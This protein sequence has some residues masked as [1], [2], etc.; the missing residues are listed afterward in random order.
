MKLAATSILFALLVLIPTVSAIGANYS[1]STTLAVQWLSKNQNSDGSWGDSD[2]LKFPCTEE[3]VLALMALNQHSSAYYWGTAWLE[4]HSAGNVDYATRR[5]LALAPHG[6]NVQADVTTIRSAQAIMQPPNDGWGLSQ[7]YQGSAMDSAFALMAFSQFKVLSSDAGVQAAISFLTSVRLTGGGWS[8]SQ[9]PSFDAPTT[10][11]VIEALTGY[12]SQTVN[13]LIA[14][15]ISSLSATVNSRSTTISQALAALAY[16]RADYPNDATALLNNLASTQ[17]Y[18]GSWSNGGSTSNELI[19]ATAIV[20]RSMATA[21]GSAASSNSKIVNI[22]DPHLRMAINKA[23]GRNSMDALTEGDMAELITL[24]AAG[25]GITDLTGLEWAVNLV[26]ADLSNNDITSTA[27]LANLNIASLNLSGNPCYTGSQGVASGQPATSGQWVQIGPEGGCILS[28]ATAP[29]ASGTVYAG[30]LNGGIY[31]SIDGCSTWQPVNSGNASLNCVYS[32]AVSP[33]NA[34]TVYAGNNTVYKTIDGGSTWKALNAGI[35]NSIVQALAID[36]NNP[37]RIYAGTSQQ[38]MVRSMDGGS[39]WS[40]A[41]S[42]LTD[43][44]FTAIAVSPF[45]SLTIFAGTAQGYIFISNDGG[46]TWTESAVSPSGNISIEGIASDNLAPG[47]IYAGTSQGIFKSSDGGIT[48]A[49]INNG[50]PFDV[51]GNADVKSI[52]VAPAGSGDAV[53]VALNGTGLLSSEDGGLSWSGLNTTGFDSTSVTS[54]AFDPG[55]PGTI[56]A[57]TYFEGVGKST[58]GGASWAP[59]I[60]GMKNVPAKSLAIDPFDPSIMYLGALKC[61]KSKD[62]GNSWNAVSGL[63]D[64]EIDAL[65]H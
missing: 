23:L 50:V 31:K 61:F 40:P 25:M 9:D 24:N 55:S 44:N 22:P 21:M 15:G 49:G 30:T 58:D 1:S 42:G 43:F 32:L 36:P 57:G 47:T 41:G 48:W 3:A 35:Y 16:L 65:C 12:P 27:P 59:A 18:D 39:T 8:L 45:S 53:Y 38:G 10:A 60:T 56:Y 54:M 14:S 19:Y 37:Q 64:M 52:A 34:N 17:S 4:N 29:S 13:G 33:S 6:D 63:P 51:N 5:I 11:I 26:S 20:A 28:L 2:N 62:G 7:A 46:G